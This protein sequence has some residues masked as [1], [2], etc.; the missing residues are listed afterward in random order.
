MIYSVQLMHKRSLKQTRLHLMQ[1]LTFPSYRL[2]VIVPNFALILP[3]DQHVVPIVAQH[4][5]PPIRMT[6]LKLCLTLPIP[7]RAAFSPFLIPYTWSFT[8][9]TWS[10]IHVTWALIHVT[11]SL[12]H[13]TWSLTHVTW[14]LTHVTQCYV[15]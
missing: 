9:V 7:H 1:A 6:S 5:V 10:L 14:S 12:I 4:L 2:N 13:V 15:P 11:W 3:V 8:H